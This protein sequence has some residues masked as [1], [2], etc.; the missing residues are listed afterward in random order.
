MTNL[1]LLR[2]RK[3]TN[4]SVYNQNSKLHEKLEKKLKPPINV[5]VVTI[6]TALATNR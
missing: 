4:S 2:P 1:V 3:Y 5:T 6:L